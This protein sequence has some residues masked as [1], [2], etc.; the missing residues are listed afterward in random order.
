M[1]TASKS[2]DGSSIPTFT[3]SIGSQIKP[4]DAAASVASAG[5]PTTGALERPQTR[6]RQTSDE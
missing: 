4:G 6:N 2:L 5:L 3:F 1:P